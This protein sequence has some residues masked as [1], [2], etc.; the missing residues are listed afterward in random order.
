MEIIKMAAARRVGWAGLIRLASS[1]QQSQTQ[2]IGPG[3]RRRFSATLRYPALPH[4]KEKLEVK[5]AYSRRAQFSKPELATLHSVLVTRIA[6]R[7][8]TTH[9]QLEVNE[10]TRT[11]AQ[12]FAPRGADS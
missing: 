12:V 6:S 4:S 7:R 8:R 2:H 1:E 11:R 9:S 5:R 3:T 10:C